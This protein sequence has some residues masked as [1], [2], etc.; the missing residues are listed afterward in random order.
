MLAGAC[1]HKQVHG[2][3]LQMLVFISKFT[4]CA[5]HCNWCKQIH[6]V[7]IGARI[8]KQVLNMYL[9]LHIIVNKFMTCVCSG[10][11][12][13]YVLVQGHQ[14]LALQIISKSNFDNF[15]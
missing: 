1:A 15:A 14:Y 3:C 10:R 8:C 13:I 11:S 5:C 7:F 4:C 9:H 12:R 2:V 6:G